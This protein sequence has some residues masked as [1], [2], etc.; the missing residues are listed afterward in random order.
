MM[1]TPSP[2]PAAAAPRETV[3]DL[4]AAW[5]LRAPRRRLWVWAIGGSVDAV[6]I[7]LV[8]P[9][10]WLVAMPLVSVAAIGAWGLAAQRTLAL[11][12]SPAPAPRRRRALKVAKAAALTLGTVA[13]VAALFGA[14]LM[15]LGPRWGPSGG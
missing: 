1:A 3:Y 11:D 9:G 14:L 12:A 10:L 15:L 7:A 5:A 13:A 4:V 2:F 8:R 6:G